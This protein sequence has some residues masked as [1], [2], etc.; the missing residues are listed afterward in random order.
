MR[1]QVGFLTKMPALVRQAASKNRK[2]ESSSS[3]PL[4][5]PHLNIACKCW[6]SR[7]QPSRCSKVSLLEQHTQSTRYH[8]CTAAGEAAH[9]HPTRGCWGGDRRSLQPAAPA[10]GAAAAPPGWVLLG[11]GCTPISEEIPSPDQ[12]R[13]LCPPSPLIAMHPPPHALSSAPSH[14]KAPRPYRP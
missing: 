13:A 4:D 1:L 9:G 11:R 6:W 2:K 3:F 10:W 14:P 8:T 7:I 12:T 5:N